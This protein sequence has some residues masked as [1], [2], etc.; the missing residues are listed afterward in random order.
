MT[1]AFIRIWFH[2]TPR[3]VKVNRRG[4]DHSGFFS[5]PGIFCP[6]LEETGKAFSPRRGET[7]EEPQSN[8]YKSHVDDGKTTRK[9]LRLWQTKELSW[10]AKYA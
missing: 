8:G 4:A 3:R 9:R 10:M 7:A 2:Y 5:A 6:R 1:E